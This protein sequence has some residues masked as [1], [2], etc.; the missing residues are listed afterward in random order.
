[1]AVFV[2][3]LAFGI[4]PTTVWSEIGSQGQGF[5]TTRGRFISRAAAWVIAEREGQLRWRYVQPD[6][7]PELHSGELR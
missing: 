4:S 1:M 5:T 2:A 7:T 6:T 3:S